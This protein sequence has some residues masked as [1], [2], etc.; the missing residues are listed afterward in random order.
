KSS[1]ADGADVL[2]AA[3]HAPRK[4]PV[5][6]GTELLEMPNACGSAL[7]R[8]F[9]NSLPAEKIAAKTPQMP[10]LTPVPND[11]HWQGPLELVR[12]PLAITNDSDRLAWIS[13]P[14]EA[15]APL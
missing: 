8:E 7:E 5:S 1:L 13:A 14:S 6:A 2:R 12:I 9:L 15:T 4:F 10:G 11:T 3:I